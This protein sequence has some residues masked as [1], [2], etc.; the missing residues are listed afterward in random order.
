MSGFERSVEATIARWHAI[1]VPNDAA[2]RLAAELEDTIEAFEAVRGTLRF[3]EE[4][5]AFEIALQETKD[6]L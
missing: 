1:A 4:P 5:A 3:E 6:T 2:R